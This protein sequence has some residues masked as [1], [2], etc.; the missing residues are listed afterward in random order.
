MAYQPSSVPE[1]PTIDVPLE[2]TI[3]MCCD[4]RI[5]KLFKKSYNFVIKLYDDMELY[6][7]IEE[8]IT[9]SKYEIIKS[10]QE[11][12]SLSNNA[13]ISLT[14]EQLYKIFME[15]LDRNNQ[16]NIRIRR[17]LDSKNNIIFKIELI[18]LNITKTIPIT[19]NKTE[20][21]NSDLVDNVVKY[22]EKKL[23]N[24]EEVQSKLEEN[25]ETFEEIQNKLE[26]NDKTTKNTIEK[27]NLI[28][29]SINELYIQLSN[30]I[31]ANEKK[32]AEM[33]AEI[34]RLNELCSKKSENVVNS[35]SLQKKCNDIYSFN[36]S[37]S[38]DSIGSLK[39][40][41]KE[42]TQQ[43]EFHVIQGIYDARITISFEDFK[44]RYDVTE[45]TREQS[46]PKTIRFNLPFV[47]ESNQISFDN[48][49]LKI[50]IFNSKL[51]VCK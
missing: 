38:Y 13:G 23:E 8:V 9:K 51:K 41:A 49:I 50:N 25:D 32:M 39:V 18:I 16:D 7:G 10:A 46:Y 35:S 4:D 47:I 33:D 45:Y 27:V 42:T 17:G 30:K 14:S 48:N 20:Q 40:V 44:V 12:N 22:L 6:I 3:L 29:N 11:I 2:K 15:F 36:V 1:V 43:F 26:E 28:D 24:F 19:L 21:T 34:K 37:R 5:I 31:E